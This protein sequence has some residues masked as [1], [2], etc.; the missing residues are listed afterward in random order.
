LRNDF[1]REGVHIFDRGLQSKVCHVLLKQN[2][3]RSGIA[4]KRMFDHKLS[5]LQ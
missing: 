2:A 1:A 4:W 3:D 5:H